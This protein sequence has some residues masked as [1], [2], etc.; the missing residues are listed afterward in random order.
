MPQEQFADQ[1]EIIGVIAGS[2]GLPYVLIDQLQQKCINFII[3]ALDL[4]LHFYLKYKGLPSFYCSLT[5][6]SPILQILN[7][8]Q[9]SKILLIGKVLRPNLASLLGIDD[10]AKKILKYLKD[11]RGGDNNLLTNLITYLEQHLNLNVLDPNP[12]LQFLTVNSGILTS[13]DISDQLT[14]D[15]QLGQD[16]LKFASKY[17]IGQAVVIRNNQIIAV[18]ALEGTEK[19]LK[20]CQEFKQLKPAGV[21]VKQPK[22]NQETKVD[23][24]TIGINTL[25]QIKNAGIAAVAITAGKTYL[26]DKSQMLTY[27]KNNNIAIVA[28]NE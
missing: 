7:K 1:N 6:V 9:I 21:L 12:Y 5:R 11:F 24:P 20:R 15:I 2:E 10:E 17:D 4:K 18:E 28:I 16:Y 26:V 27:A 22:T 25:K 23:I 13:N 14:S 8:F 3:I 19:M